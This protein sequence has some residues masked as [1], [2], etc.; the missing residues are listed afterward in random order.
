MQT[1]SILKYGLILIIMVGVC[2]ARLLAQSNSE[3]V[4]FKA[5]ADEMKRSL[6]D[7]SLDKY[8]PPFFIAY[9]VSD[10][11]AFAI[12]A[13]LG[14]LNQTKEYPLRHLDIRLMVG[15][16]A[17]N[18]E[19]FV[20]GFEVSAFGDAYL[21]LP[22]Q[23]DYSAIRK[24]IWVQTDGIYKSALDEYEQKLTALKQQNK[25]ENE[26]LDDYSRMIP[27]NLMLKEIPFTFN[28]ARWEE[29]A[30][31]L[32]A[33]FK[34]DDRIFSSAV[35]I[36]FLNSNIYYL[37]SEGTRLRYPFSIA[38]ITIQAYTQ[39]EDGEPLKDQVRFYAPTADQLP[40]VE[41]IK[42]GVKKMAEDLAALRKAPVIE[43]AYNGPVIFEGEAVAELFLQKLFGSD[44]LIAS[45]EPIYAIGR[46]G[47]APV[48]KFD[49]KLN[50]KI[51][52]ADISI[53][54]TPKLKKVNGLPLIGSYEV[55]SEGVVPPDELVLVDKGFLKTLLN[56]RVPTLKVKASNGHSRM[57]LGGVQKAPG[58]IQ[59]SVANGKS[60][61]DL[62]KD[63]LQEAVQN[64]LE[65]IYLVRKM[66]AANTR[67]NF[68][69]SKPVW[70]YKVSVKTGAEQLVRSTVISDFQINAF[71][72]IVSGT[73]DQI[74]YN[75]LKNNSVPV[76]F[77]VPQAVVINDVNLEKDPTTKPK[78]PVVPNP[79][80]TLH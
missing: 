13:T 42:Q 33:V 21:P 49:N 53:K 8:K 35:N 15:D 3:D 77:I 67:R 39:A 7:L 46:Q 22:L 68:T 73:T 64:G 14:A 20:G 60:N 43:D 72:Q 66:E 31:D 12:K 32:S 6:T 54:A 5:L 70:V 2:H 75:T 47:K 18:D 37:N 57:S 29:V 65:Y 10:G 71:K 24:A 76:S 45:R 48:N 41:K 9:Q 25:E 55:D 74:V 11:K 78:L 63:V 38:W 56:D 44:G 79:I 1:K 36:Y 59:V 62:K 69:L 19:N 34:D 26:K 61:S 58:V 28:R 16:Y 23:N 40:P 51:C 52:S 80:A 27:V 17:L 50:Q 30:K 4:I